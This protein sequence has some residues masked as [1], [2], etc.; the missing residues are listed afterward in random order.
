MGKIDQ[1]V[2]TAF[3]NEQHRFVT[4]LVFTARWVQ[5]VFTESLKPFDLSSQQ[6]NILRI[7]N[8]AKDWLP[9]TEVKDGLLEKAP[10]ATRLVNKLLSKGL[11]ERHRSETDRRVVYVRIT[12]AGR[13]L[14]SAINQQENQVQQ[15]LDQRITAEEAQIVS[16]ILDRFRG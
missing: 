8:G 9:M 4:N 11:I 12:E 2:T 7:L 1:E 3:A 15:A 13:E 6:Y 14:F 10:N 16:E 5:N